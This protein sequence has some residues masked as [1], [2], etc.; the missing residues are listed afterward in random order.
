MGLKTPPG[1]EHILRVWG[2]K[3]AKALDIQYLSGVKAKG[4]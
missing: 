4:F 1:A 2:V 3:T